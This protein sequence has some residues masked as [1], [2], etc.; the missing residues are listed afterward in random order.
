MSVYALTPLANRDIFEIWS[1][2]AQHSEVAADRVEDA[3]F[4]ACSFVAESPLR[5]HTRTDLT[6]HPLRFWTLPQHPNYSIVYW[7]DTNPVQII[8][9]LH[10]KRNLRRALENR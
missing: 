8:A 10:G 2:I 1:F 3:I 9:V 5:G 4:Q 6:S 7:P